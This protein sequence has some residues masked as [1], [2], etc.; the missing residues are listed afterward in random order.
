[1]EIDVDIAYEAVPNKDPVNLCE[2]IAFNS[3]LYVGPP[4]S[5]SIFNCWVPAAFEAANIKGKLVAVVALFTTLTFEE[6]WEL[7]EF[8]A[9]GVDKTNDAVCAK[10]TY[11]AVCAKVTYEAVSAFIAFTTY[12]AVSELMDATPYEAVAAFPNKDPVND[13]AVNEPVIV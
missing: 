11:D 7:I 6:V 4:A 2:E 9:D 8:E 5:V 10:V 13:V 3:G 12:E 1:M